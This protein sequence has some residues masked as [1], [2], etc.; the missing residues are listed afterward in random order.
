MKY[1]PSTTSCDGTMIGRRW[2]A[3][4]VVRR[5]HQRARL[6][7]RLERQRHVHGHLSPSKSG[8]NAVQTSGAAGSPCPRSARARRP[9]CRG[10]AASARGS[11]APGARGS[12]LRD[13]P[14]LGALALHH[15]LGAL[16]VEASPRSCS[17]W[18]MNGLNSSSAIF[19]GRP[20]W[21]RRSVGPTTMTSGP[22]SRRACRAGSGGSGLLALIM[23]A[24]DLSGRLLVPVIARPRRRCRA[25]R[26]PTPAA[27]ASR[28]AR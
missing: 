1:R 6:E 24:S 16:M 25:A 14:H 23:S 19:F 15:A 10:G 5:Q 28:C 7:L 20:H 17:F 12:P 11:A 9:G 22:S 18:K 26:P 3:R 21:C 2:P 27:C 8:L 13:V 4:D